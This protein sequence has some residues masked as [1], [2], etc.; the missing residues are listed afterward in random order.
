MKAQLILIAVRFIVGAI[1]L[2][3]GVWY[4]SSSIGGAAIT[5][6]SM[7]T[8]LNS[9]GGSGD[10]ASANGCFLCG[11]IAELFGVIG[12]AAEMFWTAMVGN[13]W[14]VMAIGFGVFLFI[15]TGMYLFDAMK[16]TATLDEKE[17]KL[18]LKA[19]GDKIWHQGLRV[20]I[21][22]AL[23]GALNMGGTAA[24]RT[25]SQITITPVMFV[26]AELSMAA[27]GISDSATCDVTMSETDDILN[28]ILKPFM[29]TMG[30]LNS[31][32]LAGA[33]GGFSLM[34][35][36]WLGLGGGAFTWIAGLALVFM[37]LI[38]GFNLFFQVL[39]V[40]FKLIFIIIFMP[41][42]L[43]A[44][45]FEPV[46]KLAAGLVDKAIKMLV[47]SA[48]Q[49]VGITLKIL[50]LYATVSYAADEYFPGPNDGYSAILPPLM[51]QTV[52]NPDSQTLSVMNVF[53]EC[54]RVSLTDGK[55]DADKFKACFNSKKAEVE[56]KHPGA[57]DFM[58]DGLGFLLLMFGLFL[59]YYYAIAP[60]IDEI[61]PKE[62]KESFDIGGDIKKL[63]KLI[64]N[65]PVQIAEKLTKSL[66]KK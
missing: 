10:I 30:N 20:V 59:L 65:A 46:W 61:L 60:K 4:L 17:K 3:L 11:Y 47:Q 51:G 37:F 35:Y 6:T 32:M 21:V 49:I 26:G 34:N 31:V 48:I 41:I 42:L 1:A 54:E 56:S 24:L 45:A 9:I 66:G 12:R 62:S 55:M 2:G 5:Y 15:H 53:S 36:A 18:E 14:I 44:A 7:D 40:I 52:K 38:I 50:I 28:P 64:W 19:W 58:S 29:C 8:F 23:M 22:G 57:F 16:K 25:V 43:A 33:A 27:S 13:L 63:G 39:S